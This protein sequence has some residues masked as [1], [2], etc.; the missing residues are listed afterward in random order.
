MT[1][2]APNNI[3]LAKLY[4]Y[5]N[6]FKMPAW[7]VWKPVSPRPGTRARKKTAAPDG[8]V[9]ESPIKAHPL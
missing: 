6:I 7:S 5:A 3:Q 8:A 2:N 4:V 9:T 1:P